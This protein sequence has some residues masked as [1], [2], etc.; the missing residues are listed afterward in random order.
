MPKKPGNCLGRSLKR[1]LKQKKRSRNSNPIKFVNDDNTTTQPLVSITDENDLDTFFREAQLEGK[2]FESE[3]SNI[4]KI[5]DQKRPLLPTIAQDRQITK[6][7]NTSDVLRVPKRPVWTTEMTVAQLNELE[8][9]TYNQWRKDLSL[10]EAAGNC[11]ITPFEKNLDIW[12]QLWRV[13]EKCDVIIQIVDA[14]NPTLFRCKDLEH[15]VSSFENKVNLLLIN[16]SELITAEQRATIRNEF[17]GSECKILLYSAK[18]K[19]VKVDSEADIL[20]SEDLFN[21]LNTN[22]GMQNN[23]NIGMVGYPNVGKSSTING[24]LQRK[25][26]GVSSTPGKTK[27][28]QT[29]RLSDNMI[30]YDCPGLVFPAYGSSRGELIVNGILSVDHMRDAI[31]PLSELCQIIPRRILSAK[32]SVDLSAWKNDDPVFNARMFGEAYATSHSFMTHKG[33]PDVSRAARIIIKDYIKG[34]LSVNS[35]SRV[36]SNDPTASIVDDQN[37][38]TELK[39]TSKAEETLMKLLFQMERNYAMPTS[40][41]HNIQT[42][43]STLP[44]SK[45]H[46]KSNKHIK[47]RNRYAYL[48][49]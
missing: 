27:H 7:L 16:K 32:Y 42:P 31:E 38:I 9:Q 35:V 15:Y 41:A 28:F 44:E 13:I 46:F 48:D 20:S 12:R 3:H 17:E 1:N 11:V 25:T 45:K 4:V 23:R 43:V 36:N 22:F 5:V 40:S 33:I 30:L 18:L 34:S 14:R 39:G 2:R 47:A 49:Y 29:I 24:L 19:S 26:V 8:E 37:E 6:Q 10:L 21:Y